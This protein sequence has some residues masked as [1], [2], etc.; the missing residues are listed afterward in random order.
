MWFSSEKQITELQ[1]AVVVSLS[2]TLIGLD[3]IGL[4]NLLAVVRDKIGITEYEYNRNIEALNNLI[5]MYGLYALDSFASLS[6][7]KRKE[8]KDIF[9]YA[10]NSGMYKNNPEADAFFKEVIRRLKV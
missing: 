7:D 3:Y 1:K 9:T 8:I 6:K 10:F 2:A 5:T 4:D